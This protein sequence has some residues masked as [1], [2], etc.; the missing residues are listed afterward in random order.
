LKPGRNVPCPCGSGRKYKQCCGKPEA[1]PEPAPDEHDGAVER[2]LGW[3]TQHHRKAFAAA[4]EEEVDAAVFDC[5]EDDE[6]EQA[7]AAMAGIDDALWQQIQINFTEWLLAEGDITVKGRRE[8]VS[9]LLLGP[10][11]PLFTVGQR[12]WLEQLSQRPLRLY[13]VTEVVAG[14]GITLCDALDTAA[15][16]IVVAERDAAGDDAWRARDERRRRPPVVGCD[17]SVHVAGR[18][19]H[20][21]AAALAARTPEPP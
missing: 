9:E 3:L 8:R 12:A 17:L 13:D 2:A 6:E 20:A 5:F 16:P 14:T 4:L 1:A 7:R 21:G 11:G 19:G 10:R 18:P 15:S